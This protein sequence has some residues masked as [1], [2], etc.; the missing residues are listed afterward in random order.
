MNRPVDILVVRLLRDEGTI[1]KLFDKVVAQIYELQIFFLYDW[2][3]G[4]DRTISTEGW[5][6]GVG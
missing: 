5:I 3:G 6:K 1:A 2:G 4:A